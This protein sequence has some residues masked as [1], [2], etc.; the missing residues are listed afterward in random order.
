MLAFARART[1]EDCV[2][3]T[4]GVEDSVTSLASAA[5]T[6]ETVLEEIFAATAAL[7]RDDFNQ[8]ISLST[9]ALA[10]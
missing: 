5:K 3:C 4:Q 6:W 2:M 9:A 1:I 8:S 10:R 7:K